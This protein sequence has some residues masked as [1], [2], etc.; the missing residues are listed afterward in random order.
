MAIAMSGSWAEREIVALI[1]RRQ[2]M[3]A[4]I[5]L[6]GQ[7][8]LLRAFGSESDTEEAS[9]GARQ[10]PTHPPDSGL[11]PSALLLAPDSRIE[12][13][14]NDLLARMTLDEK[15]R[16]LCSLKLG[17]KANMFTDKGT[18]TPEILRKYLGTLGVG[19]V[20]LPI[21]RMDARSGTEVTNLIQRV[22]AENTRLGIP[23]IID[24]EGFHG[25]RANGSCIFPTGIALGATWNP[26]LIHTISTIVGL[27][28]HSRGLRRIFAPILDLSHDPRHGRTEETYGEDPYLA[29]RLGVAFV[30]GL[31]SQG[32]IST[33]KHFVA[34]FVG[35]GGRD[36]GD[37]EL[38]E[39]SL[40]ELYLVPFRAAVTEGGALGI[41][42]AYNSLNGV[43]CCCNHWLLT[44]V[45]RGEWNFQGAV[46][47][48]WNAIPNSVGD[49]HANTRGEAARRAVTAG[50]DIETPRF[51]VY[52]GSLAEE[53]RTGHCNQEVVDEAVRRVLR[54]KFRL[55][56]FDQPYNEPNRAVQIS[57]TDANR[58]IALLAARESIVLLRNERSILPLSS[59]LKTIA[60]IGPNANI[61]RLGGY[62]P[63][64]VRATSPLE[65]LADHLGSKVTLSY[66]K[67]CEL[68][69]DST[70]GF[71][72]AIAA[73]HRSDVSILFVGGSAETASEQRDRADL[74]LT[75]KQEALID[76]VAKVGKPVVV[77]LVSGGPVT[78]THWINKV[79]GIVMAWYAGEE[80]GNAI[81]EVLTGACNPSG[82][83]PIT[84]PLFTGQLPM[85]YN[86]RPYGRTGTTLEIPATN[87]SVRYDPLFPFGYGQS[88][89]TF[90]YSDLVINPQ[91]ILHDGTIRISLKVANTGAR[92]GDDIVQLYLRY[93]I[94]RITQPVERLCAFKRI[95]L[96]A[97][98]SQVVTFILGQN[99]LTFLNEDLKPEVNVGV[100]SILVGSDSQSGLQGIFEVTHSAAA[101]GNAD[102]GVTH[103]RVL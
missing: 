35:E 99:D 64:V 27:E 46:V 47:S 95:S 49:L 73:A 65:A 4:G 15:V 103:S 71:A 41:M 90:E 12:Q 74:D 45:L 102:I 14:V 55:G 91:R 44:D 54:L 84:F 72:E 50:T 56:L 52:N 61:A 82:H 57:D 32:V 19:S 93:G 60:V 28:A 67:G 94:C 1:S 83:L 77:V 42:C 96:A 85:P 21:A 80:G 11:A 79:D 92:N 101:K 36:S 13:R 98:A 78:M 7:M 69:G 51:D 39:R 66:A 59:A 26:D 81:A 40:R 10:S 37:I 5:A 88:Y 89:T 68:T 75:G 18:Y 38:S 43:P 30:T 62:T 8:H 34:N 29:S 58:Q 20:S 9:R 23:P 3:A 17:E 70:D 48:D 6:M 76:A 97:G 25:L 22:S 33:P 87:D 53:V 63:E 2:L 31:Q 86:H 24:G 16:Q 100:Y